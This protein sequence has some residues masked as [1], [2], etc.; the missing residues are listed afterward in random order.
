[1]TQPLVCRAS[2]GAILSRQGARDA[3]ATLQI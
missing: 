3:E 2:N 1:M